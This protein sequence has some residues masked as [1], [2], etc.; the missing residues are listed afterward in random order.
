MN[1]DSEHNTYDILI[2]K[3]DRFIRKYYKNQVLKGGIYSFGM[4]LVFYLTVVFIEYYGR[5]NV[6]FRTILFYSFIIG[7]LGIIAKF[8]IAP[9]IQLYHLGERI[10]HQ[11]AAGIIGN[12]FS[13]VKDKLLNAMQ[14]HSMSQKGE[15]VDPALIIASVDQKI[16]SL[17]PIAFTGAIDFKENRRYVKYAL[18]P[19]FFIGLVWLVAPSIITDSTARLVAH[20]KFFE[21]IAPFAFIIT[22]NTLEAVQ[23]EDFELDIKIKGDE[24]PNDVYIEYDNNTYRLK[25]N[26]KLSFRYL[27]KNLQ[28]D[29]TFKLLA[30]GFYSGEYKLKVLPNPLIVDFE[31]KLDYP[32][33]I[34]RQAEELKN[35]G[36]M[37]I[38]EGTKVSWEF[39]TINTEQIAMRFIESEQKN[40]AEAQ[41]SDEGVFSYSVKCF[42]NSSYTIKTNNEF[43]IGRDS[44]T[45]WINVVPDMFPEIEVDEQKDSLAGNR[46]FFTGLIKDDYGF[47][48][49]AFNFIKSTNENG[50]EE[51]TMTSILFNNSTT[52]SQFFHSWDISALD[53]VAG[54]KIEYYF[55]VWDNDGVN[56]S[57]STKS[58]KRIY[59]APSLKE[60]SEQADRKNNDIKEEIEK[61]A[62]LARKLQQELKNV[63]E[64]MLD[65]KALSW[66]E[67]K[68]L[69]DMLETQKQLQ[70]NMDNIRKD[71]SQNFSQQSEYKHL[72]E[73]ILKKQQQLEDLFEKVMTDEMKELFK[74][75]EELMDKIDKNKLQEMMDKM[76]MD[77]KDIEKELDRSLELFK[78]LEVEQKL[79]DAI[80]KLEE[81]QKKQEKLSDESKSKKT[82]ADA[83]KKTQEEI[84]KDFED[85]KKDVDEMEKLNDE[86]EHPNELGS[87]KDEEA[88]IDEEINNSSEKLSKGNMGKAS[89]A[90]K[91]AA[92]E[93][94]RMKE[95]LLDMQA[96]MEA[97]SD[98]EDLNALRDL[99]E[100]LVKLSFDQEELMTKFK[101][102]NT[103]SPQYV[104]HTKTQKKLKDDAK[105]IEDSLYA[106]S[107]RVAE[108][109]SFINRE[110][111]AINYN[112]EKTI[113]LMA[114]RKTSQA[115]SKQQYV[116]TSVNNL[117][118][119]LS[120]IVEQMQQQMAQSQSGES[121][122]KK[123]GC[124]KPGCNKPGNKPGSKPGKGKK[125]SLSSMKSLQQ[126][127]NNQIKAMKKGQQPGQSK[128][129]SK[130]L[131]KLA[132]EQQAIRNHMQNINSENNKDGTG[133]M[134][135][136][137]RLAKLM[138]ETETDLV[139][140]RITQETINRQQEILTRLLEAEKAE[141]ERE[142]DK[143]REANE[144]KNNIFGNPAEFFE[145]TRLKKR[146]ME[147]LQT[148]PAN[149]KPFYKIKVNDYF[150]TVKN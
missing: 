22:N 45:Y 66:E 29:A 150:K 132:A 4:L 145:Y 104:E 134:G 59:K 99:L 85:V 78:Q 52:Q 102:S 130:E 89:E 81:V 26:S 127:L 108:I 74:K 35:T 115:S 112:M 142:M 40:L 15:A 37:I 139:N 87:T 43:V 117:A 5:F 60:V 8:I 110:I 62:M 149:L 114:D 128:G 44:I 23:Q 7:S 80:K 41:K 61:T 20:R 72:D 17:K 58:E 144:A 121:S 95:K 109:E 46:L 124:K 31:V 101:G 33:Y 65:K 30:D 75:M 123:S 76:K 105:M 141:R 36:D 73:N 140:R 77:S 49:L 64:K 2:Y 137:E 136:L 38:P 94:E 122:C 107:K 148:V 25:K 91:N 98:A 129:M 83:L 147:L 96:E 70:K 39:N 79:E 135:D 32:K 93:M 106:L 92:E 42:R 6:G 47:E 19:I 111:S 48:K 86:L 51:L 63:T 24:L 90:Q 69:N 131:V 21:P 10:S 126:Q 120:E 50:Q 138:E 103:K 27:F 71:V 118:L 12:H 55:E 11:K 143:K 28:D 116:M 100:N 67:K 53:L 84:K 97:A 146:E 56:G 57:K 82:D 18:I 13:E 9:L 68:K 3:L 34:N 119:L 88:K 14:L 54:D 133:S 113:S 125:Q 1:I 16:A